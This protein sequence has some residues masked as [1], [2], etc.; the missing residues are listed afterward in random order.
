MIPQVEQNYYKDIRS[1]AKT[2]EKIERHLSTIAKTYEPIMFDMGETSMIL[3]AD[4]NHED[5]GK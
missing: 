5:D 1:I 2:L 4:L 3:G